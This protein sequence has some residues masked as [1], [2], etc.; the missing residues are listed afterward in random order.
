MYDF[1]LAATIVY[2]VL[3]NKQDREPG[4][5]FDWMEKET[6]LPNKKQLVDLLRRSDGIWREVAAENTKTKKAPE[7]LEIMF[8]RMAKNVEWYGYIHSSKNVLPMP[9]APTMTMASAMRSLGMH[10]Q[11][12]RKTSLPKMSSTL[13]VLVVDRD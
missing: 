12:L 2:L 11:S 7:E 4:G 9:E 8:R 13:S 6:P 10:G 3:Q 1:L 5:D